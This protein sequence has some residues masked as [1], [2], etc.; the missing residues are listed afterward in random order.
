MARLW[1]VGS[2]HFEREYLAGTFYRLRAHRPISLFL[3]TVFSFFFFIKISSVRAIVRV[4]ITFLNA[5]YASFSLRSLWY[6]HCT[7]S[8]GGFRNIK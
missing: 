5:S 2:Q 8:L 6:I 3:A 7:K 4:P 1:I